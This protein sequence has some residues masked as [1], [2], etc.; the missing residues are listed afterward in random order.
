MPETHL[1]I[2]IPGTVSETTLGPLRD[3][4]EHA[5]QSC[6]GTPCDIGEGAVTLHRDDARIAGY[7]MLTTL[8]LHDVIGDEFP[9][10]FPPLRHADRIRRLV[11]RLIGDAETMPRRM[12]IKEAAEQRGR[13]LRGRDPEDPARRARCCGIIWNGGRACLDCP[14]R[15]R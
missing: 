7:A 2:T 3:R 15:T 9:G 8:R 6:L 10:Q 11:T 1:T 4:L 5:V 14:E 12:S 13:E